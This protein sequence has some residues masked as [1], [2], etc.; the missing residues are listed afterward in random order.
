[1]KPSIQ[2]VKRKDGAR[3]AYSRFGKGP[4]LVCPA[5]WVTSLSYIFEDQFAKQFWRQLAQK[6]MVVSYDKHGCG[7]SDRDCKDFTLETE[8]L[9]LETVIGHLD[10]ERFSLL[11]S[12]MAGPVAIEYTSRHP[13]KVTRLILYGSYANGRNL[14]PDKVKS[15]LV[16][17]V[18]A[19]WGLGSKTLADIFLPGA[20]TEELQSIAR[21]Q[22]ESSSP[23][24]A[25]K[26]MELCYS[27]DVTKLLSG[28]KIPTLILHREG[29]K[30]CTIDH[31][32]QLA[33]E[34]PN[35]Q[36]K[37]L[38]G[39]IHPWWYGE[40][41]EIIEEIS[42][43]IG[44]EERGASAIDTHQGATQ[45][46]R[47]EGL[48]DLPMGQAEIV[49]QATIVFSDIVSSTDLVTELGDAAARDIFLEHDKIVRDQIAKHGGRELQ[50][51]G[52][53]FMLSFES[54]SAAIRCACDIQREISGSLGSI[55]V[56]MGINTGEVVRREGKHPFGQA[57][58]IASRIASRAKGDQ[59]LISDV[60]KQLASGGRFSFVE[61]GRFKPKGFS[62]TIKLHKIHWNE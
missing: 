19:S 16:S 22:K 56:R 39:K 61:S 43:F 48:G 8:L 45:E 46:R 60:T 55:K 36:F 53:G 17:L 52:D 38:K 11:G 32:R 2:F 24:I 1:M 54:A 20:N 50:N 3:I 33:A 51:L 31:G 18:R 59:I 9:D 57:V 25:A 30:A 41:G 42:E 49:E 58:V 44:G 34:I 28:I 62:E 15:A 12:S 4:P 29:D 7:Q 13:E 23:E 47:E 26:I 27:L 40:T 21:F 10:L 6:V 5:P 35:A 37:V 14:A